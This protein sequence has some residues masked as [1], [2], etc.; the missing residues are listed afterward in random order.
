MMI[1]VLQAFDRKRITELPADDAAALE[2]KFK[3][4]TPDSRIAAPGCRHARRAVR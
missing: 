3:R 4:H 2:A 1:E